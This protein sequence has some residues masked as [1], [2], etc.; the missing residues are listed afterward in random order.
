M[1]NNLLSWLP[2]LGQGMMKTLAIWL[3]AAAISLLLG[4][5]L[6][7]LRSRRIRVPFFCILDGV[8]FILRAVPFYVLLLVTYFALPKILGINLSPLVSGIASLGLCSA[9]YVSQMVRGGINAVPDEQWD[10]ALVLGLKKT[11]VVRYIVLPQG[12]RAI[13]PMLSGELDQLLK[14][15]SILSAIGVLEL[16]RAGMNIIARDMEVVGAYVAIA[17][18]YVILSSLLNLSASLIERKLTYAIN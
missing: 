5:M 2:L 18:L 3:G 7:I 6:G 15:T 14:S 11:D 9:A 17:A 13:V 8:T 16:T 10:S 12:L 1:L 4:T